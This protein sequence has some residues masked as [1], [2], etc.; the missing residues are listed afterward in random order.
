MSEE[1]EKERLEIA[2]SGESEIKNLLKDYFKSEGG[3]FDEFLKFVWN[4]DLF[5]KALKDMNIDIAKLP[6]GVLKIERVKKSL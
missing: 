5:K 2:Q 6:I 4:I 3:V 1:K